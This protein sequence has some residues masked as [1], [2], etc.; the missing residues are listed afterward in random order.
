MW[1]LRRFFLPLNNSK[2]I[3]TYY[4]SKIYKLDNCWWTNLYNRRWWYYNILGNYMISNL[5][6]NTIHIKISQIQSLH[7]H[8]QR[9][10]KV[11]VYL[12]LIF[13]TIFLYKKT[14]KKMVKI[15]NLLQN[16]DFIWG[17]GRIHAGNEQAMI[18]FERSSSCYKILKSSRWKNKQGRGES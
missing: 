9:Q 2:L 5:K 18:E 17:N 16:Y 8:T 13:E 14:R 15:V 4:S 1:K 3:K 11:G 10:I 6:I 7:T 12:R